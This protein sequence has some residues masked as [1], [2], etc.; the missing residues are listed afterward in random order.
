M[1]TRLIVS[2]ICLGALV[3]IEDPAFQ[4]I[5]V[6]RAQS[7]ACIAQSSPRGWA[8]G[9]TVRYNI[10][11]L[12]DGSADSPREQARRAFEKWTTANQ[13][14][15]SN[16]TFLLVTSDAE[17]TVTA[18]DTAS[19][20][21]TSQLGV[22]S[23][24]TNEATASAQTTLAIGNTNF[25]DPTQPGY[26]NAIEKT[27]LHEIGHSMGLTSP[28]EETCQNQT[29]GATVMNC[30]SGV[31]DQN[32]LTAATISSSGCEKSVLSSMY[33]GTF[34]PRRDEDNDNYAPDAGGS[35]F[36]DSSCD[37]DAL[38]NPGQN[39]YCDGTGQDRN[40][41]LIDDAQECGTPV[42]VDVSGNGFRLTDAA[43]G[44]PF[45]LDGDGFAQQLSWTVAGG[46]DA[47]L[48]LDRNGNGTIDN[49]TELFGNFTPQPPS[50][51]SHGFAA[52]AVFDQNGDGWI[53]NAEVVYAQLRLWTDANHDGISQPSELSTLAKAGLLRISLAV[54]ESE[55]RDRY[56]NTYRYRAKIVTADPRDG[57]PYAYDVFLK[58]LPAGQNK[59]VVSLPWIRQ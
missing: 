5:A 44:V 6:V 42:I 1:K 9:R 32:N 43:S 11:A 18:S 12:P 39:A 52:L 59:S 37:T 46:D 51:T 36:E 26:A 34:A 7:G 19:K 21:G 30:A 33:S 41:N 29:A 13:G 8:K 3:A 35:L 17:F 38:R 27:M 53:D 2:L 10:S 15:G 40:C 56:G 14:N 31:N 23:G 16:V 55:R 22:G 20:R 45:D 25:F 28:T 24:V 4:P 57:G 50:A 54:K 58:V 48:T 49:G 47:W